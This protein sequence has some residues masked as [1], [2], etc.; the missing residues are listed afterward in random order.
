MALGV[1]E[2]WL[3]TGKLPKERNLAPDLQALLT[4]MLNVAPDDQA[5]MMVTLQAQ[6]TLA[7]QKAAKLADIQAAEAKKTKPRK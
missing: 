6:L 2:D 7:K 5:T 4:E 1:S 3:L